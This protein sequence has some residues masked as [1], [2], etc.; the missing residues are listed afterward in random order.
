MPTIHGRIN[1]VIEQQALRTVPPEITG[2][3]QNYTQ[4]HYIGIDVS[5]AKLDFALLDGHGKLVSQAEVRNTS[6]GISTLLKRW[7]RQ[8]GMDRKTSLACLEPTGHYSDNVLATL[9]GQ[10]VP[11]WMAH[12]MDIRQ[13][14]GLVRGKNDRIDA[15]RIADYAMRYQD[16]KRQASAT[17]LAMLELK[18]LLAFRDRLVVDGAKHHVYNTDLYPCVAAPLRAVFRAYSTLCIQRTGSMIKTVDRMIKDHIAKDPT[19][20]HQY[21]LLLSVDHVGPVLAAYLLATTE[22]FTRMRK[23]RQLACHAGVA[24][25]DHTSGSSVRGKARVSHH[26]DKRLKSLLHMAALGVSRSNTELSVYYRRKVAEG[27]NKMCVLNAVRNKIIARVCAVIER[28]TPYEDRTVERPTEPPSP[29][30]Q[31][32]TGN[33]TFVHRAKRKRA[34]LESNPPGINPTND[35]LMPS[36]GSTKRSPHKP[37]VPHASKNSPIRLDMS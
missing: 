22:L 33:T 30:N 13:R 28:C 7:E 37:R 10:D 18:Q 27:K 25:H 3:T 34:M 15:A 35:G 4:M 32:N 8:V 19:M 11:T 31:V 26:A 21:K 5:K 1:R 6:A 2:A 20:H 9:L 17:T 12:P 24:P 29:D 16:K 36:A 23:G 14:M